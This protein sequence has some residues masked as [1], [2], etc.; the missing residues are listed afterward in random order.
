MELSS[1][2]GII[3][4][5]FIGIHIALYLMSCSNPLNVEQEKIDYKNKTIYINKFKNEYRNGSIKQ[6]NIL[7]IKLA[8]ETLLTCNS[9]RA[10]LNHK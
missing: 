1:I 4:G 8:T 3:I 6:K 9:V 5:S 7:V 2:V 10:K